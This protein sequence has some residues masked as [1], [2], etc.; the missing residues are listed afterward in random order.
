VGKDFE[1][2]YRIG[3]VFKEW[4]Q[5]VGK[6][7][8]HPRWP[9]ELGSVGSCK[10]NASSDSLLCSMEVVAESMPSDRVHSCHNCG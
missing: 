10:N 3:H 5:V 1:N 6:Y 4:V 8:I 2:G 9:I 7:K